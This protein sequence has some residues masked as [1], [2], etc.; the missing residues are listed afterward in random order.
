MHDRGTARETVPSADGKPPSGGFSFG[1]PKKTVA[2]DLLPLLYQGGHCAVFAIARGMTK[3]RL[4]E[5]G[6]RP[7]AN[8]SAEVRKGDGMTS[9]A[10]ERFP[11]HQNI[12]WK[13]F[14]Y[15]DCGFLASCSQHLFAALRY[16][17]RFRED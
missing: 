10:T 1:G 16:S 2:A 6:A 11:I 7:G 14:Q 8:S 15:E 3:N 13:R 9:T 17:Q 12:V 5:L 4:D